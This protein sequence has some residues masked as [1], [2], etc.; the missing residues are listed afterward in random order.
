MLFMK[1]GVA[2]ID[3]VFTDS[4]VET[5]EAKTKKAL[6]DAKKAKDVKAVK[7]D[8]SQAPQTQT[9]EK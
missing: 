5:D 4:D 6:A 1:R 7:G 3:K 8:E 2:K 9:T